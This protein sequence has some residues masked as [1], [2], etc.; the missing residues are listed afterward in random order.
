MDQIRLYKGHSDFNNGLEHVQGKNDELKSSIMPPTCSTKRKIIKKNCKKPTLF[1]KMKLISFALK[2]LAKPK[3]LSKN[4]SKL[5][6]YRFID[7]IFPID[8]T[9]QN[10]DT[11]LRL[12][13]PIL[14]KMLDYKRVIKTVYNQEEEIYTYHL[15][16]LYPNKMLWKGLELLS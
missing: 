14:S 16:E 5:I 2:Y 13:F 11:K 7:L 12:K 8:S 15:E 9:Y 10:N 1:K 3:L 6:E 4:Q